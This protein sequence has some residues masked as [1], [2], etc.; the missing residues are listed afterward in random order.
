LHL[1]RQ[2]KD[3]LPDAIIEI[4]SPAGRPIVL[5]KSFLRNAVQDSR[6]CRGFRCSVSRTDAIFVKACRAGVA[7]HDDSVGKRTRRASLCAE[8]NNRQVPAQPSSGSTAELQVLIITSAALPTDY[9]I[10][11]VTG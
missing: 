4:D 9:D 5:T 10:L 11:R 2:G 3:Q 7:D 8:N 6:A 1:T